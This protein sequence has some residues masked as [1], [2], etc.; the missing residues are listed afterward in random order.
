MLF[1]NKS[2]LDGKLKVTCPAGVG[3]YLILYELSF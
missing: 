2:A 3:N 1:S